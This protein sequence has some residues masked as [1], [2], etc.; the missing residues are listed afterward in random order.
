MM[1]FYKSIFFGLIF[2]LL[3]PIQALGT[4]RDS[5]YI[6]QAVERYFSLPTDA[7]NLS[8]N[9]SAAAVCQSSSCI[10]LN[11]AGLGGLESPELTL[12]LEQ[13]KMLGDEFLSDAKIEQLENRGYAALSLPLK[14][15]EEFFGTISIAYSRYEGDTDDALNT[16]PDG[17]RRS[18]AYGLKLSDQI[19]FGYAFHFYD[20]QL[21]SNKADLHSHSRLLHIFGLSYQLSPDL[22]IGG[23]FKLGIGQSD[24]EDFLVESNGLSR[25]R[26]YSGEVGAKKNW[27]SF[28]TSISAD[29]SYLDSD[30]NLPVSSQ[31][32]VIGSDEHGQI[33]NVR[34]GNEFPIC[35]TG[36]SL[37][38]GLRYTITS[39]KFSRED[40]KDLSNSFGGITVA[41]G[42]GYD[43]GIKLNYGVEY[44]T[45]GRGSWDHILTATIPL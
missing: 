4:P 8:L 23:T 22:L 42:I 7:K 26:Q 36:F 43:F 45:I 9:G 28:I 37:Q 35:E 27:G 39:Y 38:S 13:G 14:F 6:Q 17:H 2:F 40:L 18:I 29:Y 16:S 30:G 1:I 41:G 25:L 19:N 31:Q 12:S 20:D 32:V 10:F 44:N 33:F 24:T 5:F 15:D 11:P 21:L 3:V 34:L